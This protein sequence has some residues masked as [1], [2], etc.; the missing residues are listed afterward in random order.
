[1]HRASRYKPNSAMATIRYPSMSD[2]LQHR[3]DADDGRQVLVRRMDVPARAG[4]LLAAVVQ[5]A[6]ELPHLGRGRG[7]ALPA[8]TARQ[9]QVGQLV[10]VDR[11]QPDDGIHLAAVEMQLLAAL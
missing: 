3:E 9:Q 4:V 1:M 2:V 7:R 10:Q 6:Q 5:A 11:G 8:C